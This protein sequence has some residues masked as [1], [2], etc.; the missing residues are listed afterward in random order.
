MSELRVLVVGASI[1]GPSTAYW[2]AKLGANVTVIER[3]PE[4]R[5]GGQNVDIRSVGV[6]AMRKIPG[7]EE[8]VLANKYELDGMALVRGDGSFYG[9]LIS[10]GNPEQQSIVSEYEI[11]RGD[12]SRILYDMTKDNERI[13]YVFNEQVASLRHQQ[14]DDGPISVEFAS[15]APPAEYDLVV[16]CDGA[17]SR[18]RSMGLECSLRDYMTPAGIWGAY[19]T[20]PKVITQAPN[21]SQGFGAMGGRTVI[22]GPDATSEKNRI[23]LMAVHPRGQEEHATV[24][25]REAVKQGDQ[26]LRQFVARHF[27]NIGWKTPEILK[28]MMTSDDFYASEVNMVK[29][30]S[31]HKGRF[32]TVGDAGYS[33]GLSGVGTSLAMAGAYVLAG[34]ISKH[35]NDNIPAALR[36]YDANMKPLI[37]GLGQMPSF[38]PHFLG[39]QTAWGVW[40]RN[41]IFALICWTRVLDFAQRFFSGA[42]D[43]PDK[44]PLPHYE[45]LS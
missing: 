31:L 12:L 29:L 8:A 43:S 15:G 28:L 44:H 34:E 13:K 14:G 27:A 17:A 32:V 5:T 21:I 38:L 23:M 22:A 18:T 35:G 37:D 45:N 11:L 33:S 36:G 39:P 30:P 4:L 9:T 2:L 3:F 42:F 41:Q 20:V 19:F 26:S 40:L 10:T 25:F 24:P 6:A 7:M 1:A 16:A